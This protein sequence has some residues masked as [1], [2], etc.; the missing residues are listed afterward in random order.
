MNEPK[1]S[2]DRRRG[3]YGCVL[4]LT[5]VVL[6]LGVIGHVV[7]AWWHTGSL[8]PVSIPVV[9]TPF[10]LGWLLHQSKRQFSNAERLIWQDA[11]ADVLYLRSFADDR[12]R[13][14]GTT[15]LERLNS[16]YTGRAWDDLE[17]QILTAVISCGLYNPQRIA[18]RN[19]GDPE[20]PY[21]FA[22]VEETGDWKQVAIALA[23]R[24]K[25]VIVVPGTSDGLAWEISALCL[26][27][28]AAKCVFVSPTEGASLRWALVLRQ[29]ES[30]GVTLLDARF[31]NC[32]SETHS[33]ENAS[34]ST[35]SL[36][37]FAAASGVI[38]MTF[39]VRSAKEY[40]P[41]LWVTTLDHP[42]SSW[43]PGSWELSRI[44][45][46]RESRS[47]APPWAEAHARR[48]QN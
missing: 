21:G 2:Y 34:P 40:Q 29:V 8:P 36:P 19:P 15:R 39:D 48:T 46:V 11:D 28:H 4:S 35:T 33:L 7:H 31:T 22:R 30:A 32:R 14:R 42:G 43:G 13:H 44:L 23:N 18:L 41:L 9:L 26:Y 24:A 6:A 1:T 12:L 37:D 3:A 5:A 16:F 17:D 25:V 47:T 27:G 20:T 10:V 45:A 38:A